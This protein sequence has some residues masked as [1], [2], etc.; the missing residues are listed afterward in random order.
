MMRM[1]IA[2]QIKP[3]S[4][5]DVRNWPSYTLHISSSFFKHT[6]QQAFF[7]QHSTRRI[8]LS[9]DEVV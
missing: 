3:Y 4:F 7:L 6:T 5:R 1:A 2:Q 9:I 8:L